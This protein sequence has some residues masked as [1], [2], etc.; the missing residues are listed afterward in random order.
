MVRLTHNNKA[1]LTKLAAANPPTAQRQRKRIVI[2]VVLGTIYGV[3]VFVLVF[4]WQWI[5]RHGVSDYT[6][7]RA[8]NTLSL[9]S[10]ASSL[11]INPPPVPSQSDDNDVAITNHTILLTKRPTKPIVVAYAISLIKVSFSLVS[12][13]V[14]REASSFR[15]VFL[16]LKPITLMV[17]S[18]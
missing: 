6:A 12:Q 3:V 15:G 10:L 8:H 5:Y 9:L 14:C 11:P 1:T 4:H 13:L 2:Q 17:F 7:I 18:F 16:A